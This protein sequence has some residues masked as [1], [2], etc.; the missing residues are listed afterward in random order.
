MTEPR[1]SDYSFTSIVFESERSPTTDIKDIVTDVDIFEHLTL[2]YLTG[3]MIILDDSSFVERAD[4]L[5]GEKIIIKVKSSRPG[6]VTVTKTF[7]I[8]KISRAKNVNSNSR[9]VLIELIE[10]IGYIATLQNINK[11]YQGKFTDMVKAICGNYLGRSLSSS[12]TDKQVTKVIV[13]NLDPI[14]TILWLSKRA[15]TKEGYPFYCFSALTDDIIRFGDLKTM[16]DKSPINEDIPY[17]LSSEASTAA[18]FEVARRQTVK[19]YKFNSS[20]DLHL[21]IKKGLIGA[22][23]RFIDTFNNKQNNFD[24]DVIR[25]FVKRLDISGPQT[26]HLVSNKYLLDGI[27]FNELKSRSIT[28]IG[29][30]AAFKNLND[31]Y[32]SS[33]GECQIISDYK[34][35]IVSRAMDAIMKKAPMEIVVNGVDYLDGNKYTTVGSNIKIQVLKTQP[36]S[37]T[38]SPFDAKKSGN[39]LIYATRHMFKKEGYDLAIKGIR[40]TNLK[41]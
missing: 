34:G 27:P 38:T 30:N 17:V 36:E 8:S 10:D 40:L 20:D 29:A 6:S 19:N 39:Y 32:I 1:S 16:L 23:Y 26:R 18:D 41:P 22:D 24:F 28:M 25:D 21:L 4:I 37:T 2:P 15:T 35:M 5:G 14:E 12:N 9:T 3:N 11:K 31:E 33:F 7:Y 13:P